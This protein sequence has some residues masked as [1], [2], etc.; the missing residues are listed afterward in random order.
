[1]DIKELNGLA[2]NYQCPPDAF[3]DYSGHRRRCRYRPG[4]GPGL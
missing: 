4:G 2:A 1:M 3:D